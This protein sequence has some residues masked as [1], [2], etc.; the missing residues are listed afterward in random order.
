MFL[1]TKVRLKLK[2]QQKTPHKDCSLHIKLFLTCLQVAILKLLYKYIRVARKSK[3]IPITMTKSSVSEKEAT[4]NQ[5]EDAMI[6]P[7][8]TE[9][10]VSLD[11]AETLKMTLQRVE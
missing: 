8:S 7:L 1:D 9:D 2:Q 4:N 6:N 5:L 10:C 11:R 3:Y